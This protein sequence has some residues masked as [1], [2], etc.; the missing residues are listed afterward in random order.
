[1]LAACGIS[2]VWN[3][4]ASQYCIPS[5]EGTV[6]DDFID[7]EFTATLKAK[8]Y[9]F[10][11]VEVDPHGQW[12]NG[13]QGKDITNCCSTAET[14]LST[15]VRAEEVV[16][17]EF[18]P[19]KPRTNLLNAGVKVHH[20]EAKTGGSETGASP[21]RVVTLE[22]LF[23]EESVHSSRREVWTREDASHLILH[24]NGTSD[25]GK[26]NESEESF[27]TTY[28]EPYQA[29]FSRKSLLQRVETAVH[30]V[31]GSTEVLFARIGGGSS[32]ANTKRWLS[33]QTTPEESSQAPS[34]THSTAS[35]SDFPPM[36]TRDLK[37]VLLQVLPSAAC[38]RSW[39]NEN[40]FSASASSPSSWVQTTITIPLTLPVTGELLV[41]DGAGSAFTL[42][43][44]E[45]RRLHV[46]VR[47]RFPF[48]R[49]EVKEVAQ[50]LNT[51]TRSEESC[52][53]KW[54]PKKEALNRETN[55]GTSEVSCYL[56]LVLSLDP[57]FLLTS[58]LLGQEA[59]LLMANWSLSRLR[60]GS[61]I[62]ANTGKMVN[63]EEQ[64]KESVEIKNAYHGKLYEDGDLIAALRQEEEEKEDQHD[65]I[66]E[67]PKMVKGFPKRSS[68]CDVIKLLRRAFHEVLRQGYP[69]V[70]C[71]VSNGIASL[72]CTPLAF[73][74]GCTKKG[75][76]DRR[77]HPPSNTTCS[78]STDAP[79]ADVSDPRSRG[80][81]DGEI[82]EIVEEMGNDGFS[83]AKRMKMEDTTTTTTTTATNSNNSNNSSSGGS[84]KRVCNTEN[85][86]VTSLALSSTVVGEQVATNNEEDDPV[87]YFLSKCS[88]APLKSAP[89][90]GTSD[91]PIASSVSD[92]L[93]SAA[94]EA[95]CGTNT[96]DA[97]P[98]SSTMLAASLAEQDSEQNS[99]TSRQGTSEPQKLC[100]AVDSVSFASSKNSPGSRFIYAIVKK[101]D[102]DTSEMRLM[103]A[104]AFGVP[105]QAIC[106]AGMKD[107]R[108]VTYQ[109]LSMPWT[110]ESAAKVEM[111]RPQ[112]PF[113]MELFTSPAERAEEE[114]EGDKPRVELIALSSSP[115]F[116][117][118]IH[119]GELQGNAFQIIL[120]D[121]QK[122][123]SA[124][125]ENLLLVSG[126]KDN[127]DVAGPEVLPVVDVLRYRMRVAERQGFI[128]YFGQQ[129]FSESITDI[130]DHTGVYL[131][132]QD[133]C[134]AVRSLYRAAPQFYAQFPHEM[135]ARFAPSSSR[136]MQ[137]M[138]NALKLA[139]KTYFS[140]YTLDN[141]RDVQAGSVL[142]QQICET[143]LQKMSYGLR[144]MWVHAAQSVL[145]NEC[146]SR[147]VR[148]VRQWLSQEL[149]GDGATALKIPARAVMKTANEEEEWKSSTC[150]RVDC[151]VYWL[152][153]LHLPLG[154]GQQFLQW[155][156][157]YLFQLSED[158]KQSAA[159]H[160][161]T[162]STGKN[163]KLESDPSQIEMEEKCTDQTATAP[164]GVES[165]S[166]LF[167][168][169]W[170]AGASDRQRLRSFLLASLEEA[171][172]VIGVHPPLETAIVT[173]NHEGFSN[174][175]MIASDALSMAT[176]NSDTSLLTINTIMVPTSKT[177]PFL[178]AFFSLRKICGVPIATSQ[179]K[180]FAFP[181]RV[182]LVSLPEDRKTNSTQGE[183][184][185][186]EP[187]QTNLDVLAKFYLPSSCYATIFLREVCRRD[188]LW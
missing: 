169:Y 93:S 38:P 167:V 159:Y 181:T 121:V 110:A 182:S 54:N 120:R 87:A 3:S 13:K 157:E 58:F 70:R 49:S 107:K 81:N 45:R 7:A 79:T 67:S 116:S 122:V 134:N 11:V 52:V 103:V 184:S 150:E 66:V 23:D 149:G 101:V 171:V 76:R 187:T 55:K 46:A 123:S 92:V 142:W 78:S 180:L 19:P 77:D 69:Y 84:R 12:T 91:A 168:K 41:V 183:H 5:Q 99:S 83:Q 117:Q 25:S 163:I 96:N 185:M 65:E 125:P 42:P 86:T 176:Q 147:I 85:G 10:V 95:L 35:A 130:R 118:P 37:C 119:I 97:R 6:F 151:F 178:Y 15:R 17:Y 113:C 139:Y 74:G 90:S 98:L 133:W 82:D 89:V 27:P 71:Q 31:F 64:A 80:L 112:L 105:S 188:T 155:T 88:T 124:K 48:L 16:D 160:S 73:N 18:L 30:Q 131:I 1:M 108:A 152:H 146:A 145:F 20:V 177:H 59:S 53:D 153:R 72:R 60:A 75:N 14:L 186:S 111:V 115:H 32:T 104:E 51:N 161:S 127:S 47:S 143:A 166:P 148:K 136:D 137:L 36:T 141:E 129:R 126:E 94:V 132:R 8:P 173:E 179:R 154:D 40:S 174:L 102:V 29:L 138:T 135:D 170:S 172:R 156:D 24:C 22:D 56:A 158:E 43:K 109:R 26:D 128:N 2:E 50:F 68:A 63:D 140:E 144:S 62:G 165:I 9:D 28:T 39:H 61:S 106:L 114:P 33:K 44:K 100:D 34:T 4:I 21:R 57:G 162:G 175:N 164:E